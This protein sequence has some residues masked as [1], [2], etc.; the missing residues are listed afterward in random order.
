MHNGTQF[1]VEF[2][3]VHIQKEIIDNY[4]YFNGVQYLNSTLQ[5]VLSCDNPNHGYI[6]IRPE[7]FKDIINKTEER[8]YYK[9]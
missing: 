3:N 2:N 1:M 9:Y 4:P 5:Y 8:G 7:Y 6:L